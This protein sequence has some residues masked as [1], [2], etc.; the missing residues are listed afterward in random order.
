MADIG[1]S[2]GKFGGGRQCFNFAHDQ[3]I[4]QQL[5]NQIPVAQGGAG[6]LLRAPIVDRLVS[7]ALHE[8]IL[9][10]QRVNHCSVDGHVDPFEK[11]IRLMN[12]LAGTSPPQTPCVSQ[13]SSTPPVG[14]IDNTSCWA[15]C[16]SWWLTAMRRERRTQIELLVE[17]NPTTLPDG[18][19]SKTEFI[20][21][22]RTPRFGM[23]VTVFESDQLQEIRDTGLLPITDTPNIVAFEKFQLLLN[24]TDDN[25]NPLG[26]VFALHMNV[27]SC[28]RG[29]DNNKI[30]TCMEPFFPDP[31]RDGHRTGQFVDKS[32]S[33]FLVAS[34]L[35]IASPL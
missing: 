7:A 28:Q 34:P 25:G 17:F 23:S 5:L 11:T 15:A 4:V 22:M 14:Q 1:A 30:V 20:R 24:Q 31:G 2:V 33:R 9:K 18:S 16:L 8:A 10:F 21:I 13:F 26:G 35:V 27:V 32:I 19:I 12:Q 6:G 3:R 29:D